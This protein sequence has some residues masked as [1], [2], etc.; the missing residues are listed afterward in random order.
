MDSKE[1]S[2]RYC[3]DLDYNTYTEEGKLITN[4]EETKDHIANYFEELYQAREGTENYAD[5]TK[6]IKEHVR[7]SLEEPPMNNN[8]EDKINEKEFNQAIKKLKRNKSLG[9]D[10]IPNELFIEANKQTREILR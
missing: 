6:K 8:P 2:K 10:K 1:K 7:S 3:Q 4:P 9:P 5:W